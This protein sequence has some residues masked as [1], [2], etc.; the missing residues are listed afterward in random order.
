K[1]NR[2]G[3]D[4]IAD[5]ETSAKP[6]E[7][8]RLLRFKIANK[9]KASQKLSESISSTTPATTAPVRKFKR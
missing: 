9:N 6:R 7:N 4:D 1:K 2:G 3:F 5:V 8:D